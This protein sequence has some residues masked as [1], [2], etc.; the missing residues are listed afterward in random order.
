M[1]FNKKGFNHLIRKAAIRMISEQIA[2]FRLLPYVPIV[3]H[4]E[5]VSIDY[6]YVM[7]GDLQY[8]GISKYISGRIITVIIRQ[9]KTHEAYFYSVFES[10]STKPLR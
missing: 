4:S 1:R 7:N 5:V 6:R 3:L 8:W 9:E 2:R 10:D